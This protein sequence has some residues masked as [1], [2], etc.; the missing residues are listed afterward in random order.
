[1]KIAIVI[2][3]NGDQINISLPNHWTKEDVFE[4]NDDKKLSLKFIDYFNDQT[5]IIHNQL[6]FDHVFFVD[7]SKDIIND[8]P[9]IYDEFDDL[10]DYPYIGIG[11]KPHASKMA[12]FEQLENIIG[13]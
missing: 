7:I 11:K 6:Y 10:T 3:S 2:N 12:S 1:M 13:G 8:Q 4:S 5:K 9:H